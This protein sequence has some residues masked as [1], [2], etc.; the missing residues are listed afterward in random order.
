MVCEAGQWK[1]V[2][3]GP[4]SDPPIIS[5]AFCSI[6]GGTASVPAAAPLERW[7][8]PDICPAGQRLIGAVTRAKEGDAGVELGLEG[9]VPCCKRL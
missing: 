5:A 6:E 3:G 4:C 9:H 1:R 7:S 2:V 8:I